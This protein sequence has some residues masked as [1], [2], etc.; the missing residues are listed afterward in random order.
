VSFVGV[1]QCTLTAS[2]TATTDDAI[3][4]GSAQSFTVGQATQTIGF[5]TPP[6][7]SAAYGA[8]FTV[9]ATASSG[10]AVTLSSAGGCTNTATI[11]T[12]G[13]YTSTYTM[14][15]STT[16]CSVV[17]SQAGNTDYTAAPT[18]TKTVTPTSGPAITVSPTSLSFGAVAVGSITTKTVT[19]SNTGSAAAAISTPV[20]SLLQAGSSN[21]YVIVNLCPSSLAAGKSCTITVSFVAGAYYSSAQTAILKVMDNAPGSP[22]QVML[23]A[24]ILEPQTITFTNVPSS[25]VYNSQFTVAATASSGLPVTY[26]SSGSCTD[27]G[28]NPA[29]YTM[30]SGTGTCS[31]IANQAGNSTWAPA[32]QVTKS[33]SATLATPTISISN[34]PANAVYGSKYTATYSYTGNGTPSVTSSTTS[35][36]TAS[37]SSVSLVGVGTCTLKASATATTN[38]AAVTGS[39]QSF[40]VGQATQAITLTNVP[41]SAAYKS[42]FTV[43]ATA[44]SGL[45][46]TYTNSGGCS[47]SGAT[48]TMNSGT[49]ACSVIVNQAGNSDYSAAPKVSEGVTATVATQ[50]IAFTTKAP[51]T[52]AY[53]TSFT[54]AATGGAS[55]NAVTFT[56]SG[57]CSNSGT[58]YT[59]TSGTGTC[60]VIANQAGTTNEYSAAPTVTQTVSATYSTATLTPGSLNFG[61]VTSG[62]SSSAQTA[63][64][65]NTGSTPLIISSIGFTGTNA[66]SFTETN[67]CPSS[68]SSLAAG[69]KCAIAVTFKSGGTAVTANL[70]V[71]D[72][73]SA[74]TQNVSLSGK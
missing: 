59:M 31:V 65:T 50:T 70:T 47:N 61:T 71:A 10:L 60:S 17:A 25:A 57:S 2:A 16:A 68:S 34:L 24:T 7:G 48:Y 39:V 38:Y 52:A 54:V 56:S 69:A 45:A 29:T 53:K 43:T 73:T 58:T 1:G 13:A 44:S 5:T 8:S 28:A 72:N 37:G 32:S 74:G 4:T 66:S 3:A 9:A 33:V 20:L 40:T 22:Q 55:G 18:V 64:L 63:T 67:T 21:E 27:S 11:L 41:S 35:V 51:A 30:T 42:S 49:V 14:I 36:C 19:V 23:S 62:K 46:V 6:P 26:S 15:S 12:A